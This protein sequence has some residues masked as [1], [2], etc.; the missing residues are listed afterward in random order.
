[1]SRTTPADKGNMKLRI[2]TPLLL[3][4][5]AGSL[6]AQDALKRLSKAETLG[7]IT[8]KVAPEYPAAAK[9]LK[10]EGVV[11]LKVVID[12]SG[13]VERVDIVS[14]NPVLT[15][16]AAAAVKQW[17]FAPPKLD[18]KSAKAEGAVSIT[19]KL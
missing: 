15:R 6:P 11:E 17:K 4:V 18:G 9:Q 2:F 3:L 1:M 7:S 14:G 13:G 10:M 12:E 5:A 8:H 16:T 19:F